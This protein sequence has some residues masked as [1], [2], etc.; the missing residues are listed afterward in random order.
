MNWTGTSCDDDHVIV[1][2][3]D[4]ASYDMSIDVNNTQ[5][6][7]NNDFIF[8]QNNKKMSLLDNTL[9]LD[10]ANISNNNLIHL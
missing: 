9:V 6:F 5:W 10:S 3:I 8:H 2:R 1:L 4:P 7:N